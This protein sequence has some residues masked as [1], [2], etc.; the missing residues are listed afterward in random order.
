MRLPN[1]ERQLETVKDI[2]L[3][4]DAATQY[5]L[6]FTDKR[7]AIVCMGRSDRVDYVNPGYNPLMGIAPSTSTSSYQ[8]R[9]NRVILEDE[10]SNLSLD[11]KLKLSKK[12]CFY[13]YDEVEEVKLVLGKKPKF[14]ILS[15]ECESKFS[16]NQEQFKQLSD[17]LPTIEA[18]KDKLVVSGNWKALQETQENNSLVCKICGYKNDADANFCQGCGK[19]MRERNKLTLAQR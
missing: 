16:P 13:T 18:L 15:R 11:Q 3:P 17:L 4:L 8:K 19:N 7:I 5:D 10:V 9:I 1:D 6:Y 2:V 14:V 12:S